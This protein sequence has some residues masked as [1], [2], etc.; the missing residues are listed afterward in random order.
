[1]KYNFDNVVSQVDNYIWLRLAIVVFISAKTFEI[2]LLDG[3][4]MA[5]LVKMKEANGVATKET[6]DSKEPTYVVPSG[7]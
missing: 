5:C 7:I 4:G 3:V 6:K 2:P 1:M